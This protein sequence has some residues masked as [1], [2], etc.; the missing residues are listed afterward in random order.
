MV[1]IELSPGPRAGTFVVAWRGGVLISTARDPEHE[2]ARLLLARG[3]TGFMTTRW[4][5]SRINSMRF[6]IE[7]AAGLSTRDGGGRLIVVPFEKHPGSIEN[8]HVPRFGGWVAAPSISAA[9]A[10]A[11]HQQRAF[12]GRPTDS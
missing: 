8:G 9:G 2:A 5:G 11:R 1:K 4:A 7:K 12:N 10:R 6:D 3:L